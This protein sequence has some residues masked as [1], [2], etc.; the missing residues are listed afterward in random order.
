MWTNLFL[1]KHYT[2]FFLDKL[3]KN[4]IHD[5]VFSI[6]VGVKTRTLHGWAYLKLSRNLA[7]LEVHN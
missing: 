7:F 3:K 5:Q 1:Y 4:G 6:L 2:I